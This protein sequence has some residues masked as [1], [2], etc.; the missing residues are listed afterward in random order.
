MAGGA[1][2]ETDLGYTSLK[3]SLTFANL[4]I[5]ASPSK[6]VVCKKDGPNTVT[7]TASGLSTYTWTPGGQGASIVVTPSVAGTT[8]TGVVNYFVT[9]TD[10]TSGCKSI[11][12]KVTVSVSACT[13]LADNNSNGY[14]INVFPN[15]AVNGKSTVNG[16]TGTN[17]ITVYNSLGQVVFNQTV[18]TETVEID[19]SNQASG[20]YMVKISDSNSQARIIKLVNQN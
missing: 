18:S 3:G 5:S 10:A 14:N 7:L 4:A 11:A 17:V 13:G 1:P 20:N 2:V 8:G 19:L 15:P 9:G 6:S 16:L 12:A